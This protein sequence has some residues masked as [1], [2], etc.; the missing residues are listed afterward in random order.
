MFLTNTQSRHVSILI[1]CVLEPPCLAAHQSWR[2][3]RFSAVPEAMPKAMLW[4]LRGWLVSSKKPFKGSRLRRGTCWDEKK[5][6]V[7][8]LTLRSVK[9]PLAFQ[10]ALQ[11]MRRYEGVNGRQGRDQPPFRAQ[12]IFFCL[13]LT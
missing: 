13:L 6:I 9:G 11:W 10:E 5:R 3:P 4:A 1:D 7:F 12:L 2:C 8:P